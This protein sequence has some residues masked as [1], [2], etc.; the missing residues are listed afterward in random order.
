MD[1]IYKQSLYSVV[2]DH[3]NPNV[4]KKNNKLN[5]NITTQ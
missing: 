4:I 1:N 2:K 5:P 3:I